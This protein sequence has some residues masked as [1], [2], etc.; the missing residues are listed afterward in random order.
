MCQSA[1]ALEA[2]RVPLLNPYVDKLYCCL[3]SVVHRFSLQYV[4]VEQDM[5]EQFP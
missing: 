5:E 1:I 4:S 3:W 2:R